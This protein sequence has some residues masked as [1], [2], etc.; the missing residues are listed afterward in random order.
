MKSL[1][2]TLISFL[3]LALSFSNSAEQQTKNSA[4]V[5]QLFTSQG[6]SSCPGADRL[7]KEISEN[8]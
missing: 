2:F 5:L 8:F 7:L 3:V 6:C 1:I 4:V